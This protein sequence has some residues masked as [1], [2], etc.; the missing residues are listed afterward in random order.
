MQ[1][2]PANVLCD[3]KVCSVEKVVAYQQLIYFQG[4]LLYFVIKTPSYYPRDHSKVFW[5]GYRSALDRF[6]I[7]EVCCIRFYTLVNLDAPAAHIKQLLHWKQPRNLKKKTLPHEMLSAERR[8]NNGIVSFICDFDVGPL[9]TLFNI[10]TRNTPLE[11]I[12]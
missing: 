5:T 7:W 8:F 11:D 9:V 4:F 2:D 1:M 10:S 3:F 12:D 6:F